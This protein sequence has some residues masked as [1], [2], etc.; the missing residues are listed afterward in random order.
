[1][2]LTYRGAKYT[3][4]TQSIG[5]AETA[6][7]GRFLGARFQIKAAKSA[8]PCRSGQTLSYRLIKYSA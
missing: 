4:P 3:V 7:S 1:M 5:I 8:L 2:Q 6:Q